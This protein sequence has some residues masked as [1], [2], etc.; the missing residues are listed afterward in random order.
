MINKTAS[1]RQKPDNTNTQENHELEFILETALD[2][3]N[4]ICNIVGCST[5]QDHKLNGSICNK[6]LHLVAS[7]SHFMKPVEFPVYEQLSDV[8][9]ITNEQHVPQIQLGWLEIETLDCGLKYILPTK[10]GI[11]VCNRYNEIKGKNQ[12]SYESTEKYERMKKITKAETEFISKIV[13]SESNL[14]MQ[15]II[16]PEFA[17]MVNMD[18]TEG[19]YKIM[20]TSVYDAA[21]NLGS[22]VQG[23]NPYC[24]FQDETAEKLG[25]VYSSP[26]LLSKNREEIESIIIP[27]KKGIRAYDSYTRIKEMNPADN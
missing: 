13:R 20:F 6:T 3:Y 15:S 2:Q 19:I 5:R 25:W 17:H 9:K 14:L 27:T 23:R 18:C 22:C 7:M 12:V 26:C 21:A 1:G 11:G 16:T 4:Q 8:L 10:Q 24:V